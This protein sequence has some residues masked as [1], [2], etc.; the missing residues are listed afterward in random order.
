MGNQGVIKKNGLGYV[1]LHGFYGN[2]S[3]FEKGGLPTKLLISAVTYPRL[4]NLIP[5]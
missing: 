5:N 1:K 4:L 2:H 3:K